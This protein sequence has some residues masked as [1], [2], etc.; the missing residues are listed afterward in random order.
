MS[1][2]ERLEAAVARA[3]RAEMSQWDLKL[4]IHVAG[5]DRKNAIF[6]RFR[7]LRAKHKARANV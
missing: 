4:A 1:L 3:E 6:D 5:G 7:E 2:Q